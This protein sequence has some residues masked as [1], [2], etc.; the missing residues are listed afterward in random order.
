[1]ACLQKGWSLACK[2]GGQTHFRHLFTN[3]Y[4]ICLSCSNRQSC[5]SVFVCSQ[6]F[7]KKCF[8]NKAQFDAVSKKFFQKRIYFSG[9]F[10]MYVTFSLL[11]AA[12]ECSDKYGYTPLHT[13]AKHGHELLMS[14]LI[15]G[16][17]N[18]ARCVYTNTKLNTFQL[19]FAFPI[20][21][22]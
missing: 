13:A 11:G 3:G 1:M 18:I 17:A 12:V 10:Q 8:I 20:T 16:G 6:Q 5:A 14:T 2:K 15:K 21:D 19:H 7:G 9:Y 22:M 4:I